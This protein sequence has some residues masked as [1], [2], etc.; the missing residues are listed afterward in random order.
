MSD[1]FSFDPMANASS[2]ATFRELS[3]LREMAERDRNALVIQGEILIKISDLLIVQ[4]AFLGN[5][6]EENFLRRFNA[7]S[8]VSEITPA[9]YTKVK[10]LQDDML[11]LI[12]NG[13]V[14][15][16]ECV[17][18][19]K[20]WTEA[21]LSNNKEKVA[22]LKTKI[23]QKSEQIEA[24]V[25][26]IAV[27]QTQTESLSKFTRK[28]VRDPIGSIAG[29]ATP[30]ILILLFVF[31]TALS[32]NSIAR[33]VLINDLPAIGEY[34]SSPR[35]I[36]TYESR[37]KGKVNSVRENPDGTY[38]LVLSTPSGIDVLTDY[39]TP[40]QVELEARKFTF[41]PF[42]VIAVWIIAVIALV[43]RYRNR[44]NKLN[45][46]DAGIDP[47]AKKQLHIEKLKSD[48][49]KLEKDLISTMD[50]S[51][52]ATDDLDRQD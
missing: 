50:K 16:C 25:E 28:I 30:G 52:G 26:E 6:H 7:I 1:Y 24:C 9:R 42:V 33:L 19:K 51:F 29:I 46:F 15:N 37:V 2:M 23:A 43:L 8:A 47:I 20:L 35:E 4:Q 18:C 45:N 34:Y 3:A 11:S 14:S 21:L 40:E 12:K 22:S 48:L 44:I 39:A 49:D 36:G 13:Y 27:Y 31:F 10:S 41:L 38:R 5:A 32:P 17:K